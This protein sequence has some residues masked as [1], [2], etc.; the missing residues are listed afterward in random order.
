MSGY[1]GDGGIPDSGHYTMDRSGFVQTGPSDQSMLCIFYRRAVHNEIK[2]AQAGTPIYE[3]VDYVRIQQPG[4]TSQI[5]DRPAQDNDRRRWPAQW[6]AY[7][8]G[9]DQVA[10]G[11]PLGLL[12]PRHPAQVSMLQALGIMTVQH[13][14]NASETAIAAIGM[15][16]RD[17]VNYAQK[18]LSKGADGAVFHQ[19]QRD[20]E[21]AN[22]DR[23]R[24]EKLVT[25]L[26]YQVQTLNS[27]VL[28]GAGVGRSPMPGVSR[29]RQPAP[30]PAEPLPGGAAMPRPPSFGD[31]E[32]YFDAQTA[33]IN[34]THPMGPGEQQPAARSAQEA[35][36]ALRRRGPRR[37]RKNAAA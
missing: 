27:V 23:A 24:L 8:A 32:P 17:Y 11:T 5:V 30:P 22:R 1:I 20:L 19:M 9:K 12:F 37:P 33:Q 4:E 15:H 13:L 35:T 36:D 28:E 2:S 29:T 21:H 18:Y 10:D 31:E 16:G 3:N 6:Q 7:A 25:D 26:Q 34:A 14:A